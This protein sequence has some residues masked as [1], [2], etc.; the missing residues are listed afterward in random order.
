MAAHSGDDVV[1][2]ALLWAQLWGFANL[3]GWIH[4]TYPPGRCCG[5]GGSCDAGGDVISLCGLT[6]GGSSPPSLGF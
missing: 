2:T 4:E 5:G 6:A 1:A 3:H